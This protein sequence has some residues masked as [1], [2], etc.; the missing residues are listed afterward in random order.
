MLTH[1]KL[2]DPILLHM[3]RDFVTLPVESTVGEALAIIRAHLPGDQAIYFYVVD[4]LRRLVGVL[5]TRRLLTAP[6]DAPVERLMLGSVVA[7]PSRATVF[8]ACE[9][10][11]L[12]R[13][14]A[15][16]V[17]DAQ[18]R[19]VGVVDV[20]LFTEEVFDMQERRQMDELFETLGFRLSQIRGASPWTAFRLRF[21]WLL[22]TIAS[23]S[24][25]ALVASRF[26]TTLAGCVLL[27]FFLT[28]VLGLG[29][30]VSMQVMAIAIHALQREA[31]RWRWYLSTAAGELLR[32]MLL[33]LACAGIVATLVLLWQRQP[34][35]A[36]VVAAG[37]LTSLFM[38]CLLGISVPTLLHRFR[39][40]LRVAAGP[41]TLAL[42]DVC[43]IL[44]Y[45]TWAAILL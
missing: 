2:D 40:D 19:I 33:A 15:L 39:L 26:E 9:L 42:T 18:R 37:I 30:S 7:I 21:P 8:D 25:C 4:E 44:G 34:A 6:V 36:A 14:L 38:A 16:P 27:A 5:P 17:T 43:T 23:G 1:A 3:R 11:A 20:G 35:A 12:H 45:L 10:F 32:T 22:A 41:V 29:E 31:P 28:L 24:L 13:F